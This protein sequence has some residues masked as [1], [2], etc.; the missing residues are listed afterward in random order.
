MTGPGDHR[1]T[2]AVDHGTTT[3]RAAAADL[4]P[5]DGWVRVAVVGA[6]PSTG[7][8]DLPSVVLSR[9]D[10][11]LFTGRAALAAGHDDPAAVVLRARSHLAAT[12]GTLEVLTSWPRPTTAGDVATAL[13]ATV[14]RV[15]T[16]RRGTPPAALVLVHPASWGEP[17]RRALTEAGR[18]A[19]DALPPADPDAVSLLESPRAVAHRL[20]GSGPV[21]VTDLGGGGTE[22]AVV[23]RDT[24]V[25]VGGPV[26]V[27]VGAEAVDDALAQRVLD[28]AGPDLASRIRFGADHDTHRAWYGLRVG[29]REAKE[30]L[31]AQGSVAVPLPVLPPEN[32]RTS[33]VTLTHADL[34]GLL[35][36]GLEEIAQGV[37]RV[38]SGF[39][40]RPPLLVRGGLAELPRVRTWLA[41]RTGTALAHGADQGAVAASGPV[42]GAAAWVADGIGLGRTG[43]ATG[44]G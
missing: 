12:S 15:E 10:G 31:G 29:I 19:M 18:A 3:T 24:G 43:T 21:V 23:D 39:S 37:E 7:A 33:M 38:T 42:S 34:A 32:P 13:I 8:F 27:A 44:E 5:T 16:S 25:L 2:L 4:D 40:A 17:A 11:A 1:W 28:R 35:A 9:P 6:E 36:P 22:L 26:S 41:E 14:L 20:G 30:T